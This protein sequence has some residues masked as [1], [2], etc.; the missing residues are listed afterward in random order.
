MLDNL[1]KKTYN[2]CGL[3]DIHLNGA[4][5]GAVS[6]DLGD[7]FLGRGDGFEVVDH[8]G[9]TTAGELESV[10]ATHVAA[11][12]GWCL[13]RHFGPRNSDEGFSVCWIMLDDVSFR[14]SGRECAVVCPPYLCWRL[15][16]MSIGEDLT[17]SRTLQFSLR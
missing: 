9:G 6:F 17:K 15:C 10:L 16:P 2:A 5:F 4:G 1:L 13:L 8:E 7:D 3:R 14:V 12:G 11:V